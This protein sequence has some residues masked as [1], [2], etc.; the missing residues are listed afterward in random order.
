M[1]Y[2]RPSDPYSHPNGSELDAT[3]QPG[4][5]R[6]EPHQASDYYGY[7][8]SPRPGA[9]SPGNFKAESQYEMEPQGAYGQYPNQS[10]AAPYKDY[11]SSNH[12]L[13]AGGIPGEFW[14]PMHS[15]LKMD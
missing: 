13:T 9:D 2:Q 5:Y 1:S 6:D 11:S 7:S 12:N 8:A 3:Y 4:A 14:P 15:L 10:G